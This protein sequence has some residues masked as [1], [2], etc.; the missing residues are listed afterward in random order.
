VIDLPKDDPDIVKLFITFLYEHEYAA[1]LP[2]ASYLS[3]N[4]LW[5]LKEQRLP[6]YTYSF[7]H[8]CLRGCPRP[9][10]EVCPH[11]TCRSSTCGE[12]CVRFI[13]EKCTN[14]QPS[15]DDA[16]QL[17]RHAK[18]YEIADKYEVSG[19]KGLAAEKFARACKKYYNHEEFVVA[20]EHA[21]TTTPDSDE[22]LR[23]IILETMVSNFEIFEDMG[24]KALVSRHTDFAFEL[25][26]RQAAEIA[27]LKAAR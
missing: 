22:G 11:H 17:L 26:K 12:V 1:E 21:L 18:L 7:A 4:G 5:I 20:A 16:S 13:C 23:E 9:G 6:G 3:M 2:E 24:V 25:V 8:T 14:P 19:L 10:D 15:Y 27:R